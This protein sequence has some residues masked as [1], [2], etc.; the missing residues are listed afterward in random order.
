MNNHI[1]WPVGFNETIFGKA[2]LLGK[3]EYVDGKH[4]VKNITLI[5]YMRE[6]DL[7]D[8]PGPVE[9]LSVVWYNKDG[10]IYIDQIYDHDSGEVYWEEPSDENW[11]D[12]DDEITNAL[13]MYGS[14][15][16]TIGELY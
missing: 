4:R 9:T 2:Y 8:H 10:D 15:E 3:D 6:L 13:L 5:D 1:E 14:L 16:N 12:A 11:S 7:I